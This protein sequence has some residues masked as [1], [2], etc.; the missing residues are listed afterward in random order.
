MKLVLT[1]EETERFKL[2]KSKAQEKVDK[3]KSKL[4][5]YEAKQLEVL[6]KK[7]KLEELRYKQRIEKT[8]AKF[9]KK[10]SNLKSSGQNNEVITK[11]EEYRIKR[12]EDINEDYE[13]IKKN[14]SLGKEDLLDGT[15]GAHE[16]NVRI[17]LTA[18]DYKISKIN[19]KRNWKTQ[20]ESNFSELRGKEKKIAMFAAQAELFESGDK[21]FKP[22]GLKMVD[23]K[24]E[25]K[26][27][28]DLW[29][30]DWKIKFA[31][32]SQWTFKD[33]I[34]IKIW[35]IPF[36]MYAGFVGILAACIATKTVDANMVYGPGVLLTIAIASGVVFGKIP[37]WK[38][39]FGGAVMGSMFVGTFLVYFGV[40]SN[41][42][43][44]PQTDWNAGHFVYNAVL[45]W[46]KN[47]D[48]LSFYISVLLVGAVLLIPRKMII[49]SIGGFFALIIMGTVIGLILGY[50]GAMITGMNTKEL[51]LYYALP[52]LA[53]GNGG[54]IQP[55]GKIAGK[56]GYDEGA[57]ISRGLAISTLASI[58]SVVAAAI[59]NGVGKAKPSLSGNGKLML[60]DIHTVDRTAKVNDRNIASALL[61]IMMIYMLS[62]LFEKAIF[63]EERIKILV[64]NF[65]WM[66]VICLALNLA[67]VVP[68]EMKLGAEKINKFISKQTT[69]LLMVGV[70]IIYIDLKTFIAALNGE[71]LFISAL[72]VVG[73]TVGPMLIAKPLKFNA[74]EGAVS[75]GLCMTAQGGSGAIAVLG[76]SER[77]E[78]MP[79]GQITCR[80]A[81]SVVLVF[82][83]IAFAQYPPSTAETA[84]AVVAI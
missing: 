44:I 79:F 10:I 7:T 58:L 20:K 50:L 25:I 80:I 52:I 57:W 40:I 6:D 18:I 56:F 72:F 55:I 70:G 35:T 21:L 12:L 5:N 23:K 54:G 19:F 64:P 24:E 61:M 83:A 67:N 65:A 75:A 15:K 39:Y 28:Y 71:A 8:E 13:I 84:L 68:V 3:S 73:A 51:V 1:V 81:G 41:P 49:K 63:T 43:G 62:D 60:R 17:K 76:T 48:F 26:T 33:W 14:L 30:L 66:I 47:Q 53:D 42:K 11:L 59:V 9:E 74:V 36:W 2:K 82:A 37:I 46:F 38:K 45:V 22:F 4:D 77:M 32:C 29:K 34:N 31:K 78:L 16:N 27:K 69:W